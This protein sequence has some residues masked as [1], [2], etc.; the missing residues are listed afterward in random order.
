MISTE[1]INFTFLFI[2]FMNQIL[3]DQPKGRVFQV[4]D[5]TSFV[6]FSWNK[7]TNPRRIDVDF[8]LLQQISE[9]TSGRRYV[10]AG[11]SMGCISALNFVRE[12]V[13][14]DD[15]PAPYALICSGPYRTPDDY[16]D[17]MRNSR[18][19][20]ERAIFYI[21]GNENGIDPYA[22]LD[23]VGSKFSTEQTLWLV[24]PIVYERC[25]S[26]ALTGVVQQPNL[27]KLK[28]SGTAL[29]FPNNIK[30][31]AGSDKL[32]DW[33]RY[34]LVLHSHFQSCEC[35]NKRLVCYESDAVRSISICDKMYPNCNNLATIKRSRISTDTINGVA[36]L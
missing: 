16:N 17:F 27:V 23:K 8:S 14:D 36:P 32:H 5:I 6:V 31:K 21:T 11:H 13:L 26:G 18:Y 35:D 19:P 28:I 20:K 12:L 30:V 3:D 29:S 34:R 33:S 2:N 7:V 15:S 4:D 10:F 22:L 24:N 25:K 1:L 9:D